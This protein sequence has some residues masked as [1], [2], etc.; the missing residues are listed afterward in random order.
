MIFMSAFWLDPGQFAI[1]LII[2]QQQLK[3]KKY[4]TKMYH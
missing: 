1:N 3:V 2:E 4:T